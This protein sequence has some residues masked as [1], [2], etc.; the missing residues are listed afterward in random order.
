M[1][2]ADPALCE[3][4]ASLALAIAVVFAEHRVRLQ[5]PAETTRAAERVL[6]TLQVG[7]WP[8]VGK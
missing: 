6:R 1:D 3:T 2:R 8:P 5:Q 7:T 4:Y